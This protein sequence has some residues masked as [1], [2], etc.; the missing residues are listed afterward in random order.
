MKQNIRRLIR[1]SKVSNEHKVMDI[2]FFVTFTNYV[3]TNQKI[4][5]LNL[6]LST[7]FFSFKLS[8]TMLQ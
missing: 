5:S 7:S 8:F 2:A 3:V 4:S 6:F 1:C